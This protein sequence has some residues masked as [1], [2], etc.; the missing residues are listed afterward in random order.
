MVNLTSLLLGEKILSLGIYH[1][2]NL[3]TEASRGAAHP[4]SLKDS[5]EPT[6]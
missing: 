1:V 3:L 5:S 2:T 6:R 4:E